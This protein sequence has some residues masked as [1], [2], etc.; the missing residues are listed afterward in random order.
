MIKKTENKISNVRESYSSGFTLVEMM[1]AVLIMSIAVVGMIVV[2]SS[3]VVNFRYL[4]DKTS[5]TLLA[6]EGVEL[7]RNLRDS[8]VINPESGGWDGFTSS[9]SGCEEGCTFD[10]MY[11]GIIN[12]CVPTPPLSCQPIK[13]LNGVYTYG[14]TGAMDTKFTRVIKIS[15]IIDAG[16]EEMLVESTVFWNEGSVSYNVSSSE[17]LMNWLDAAPT[18]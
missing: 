4:K 16:N 10:A 5:A 15:P 13:I 7:V 1:V 6:G 17:S 18:L 11:P 12:S 14:A 2:S 9:V 3:G 8:Y